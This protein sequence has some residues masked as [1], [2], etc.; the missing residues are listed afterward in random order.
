MRQFLR[1]VRVTF[2]GGTYIVNPFNEVQETELRVEFNVSKTISG[3]PNDFEIKL[4]NISEDHRNSVGKELDDVMLEAGYAP[5]E[6]GTNVSIIAKGNVRDVQHDRDGSDIITTITCGDGDK[7]RRKASVSKTYPTG[8]PVPDIVQ[9]LYDQMKP[10][11][12]DKG[13]W[14]FPDDIKTIKRPYSMCGGC[15]REMNVLGR[16]NEFYWSVQNEV[17]EVIPSDGHL[18]GEILISAETGMIGAPTITDNGVKV[19]CLL[20]PEIR[21]NRT[22]KIESEV[23]EMNSAD[24]RYRVSAVDFEGSNQEGDFV[25][26]VHGEAINGDKVD[27]GIV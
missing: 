13:E 9:G 10:H 26:M 12:I 5:P 1:K 23:L 14:K 15:T 17:M 4:W 21:P 16:S 27:E 6:G 25:A 7:A 19:K 8:T 24:S 18:P 2:N 22:V 20:N 3:T 11:G